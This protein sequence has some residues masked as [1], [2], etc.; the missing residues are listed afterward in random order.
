[1]AAPNFIAAA[2]STIVNET[3]I[4][5]I[6]PD[7]GAGVAAGQRALL[8]LILSP[9]TPSAVPAGWTP[10]ADTELTPFGT[11]GRSYVWETVISSTADVDPGDTVTVNLTGSSRAAL[12]IVVYEAATVEAHSG[13]I[14]GGGSADP[15][16]I[17]PTTTVA[18]EARIVHLYP[19]RRNGVSVTWTPDAATTE[20][21][22]VCSLAGSGANGTILVADEVQAAPGITTGRTGIPT[23][24]VTWSSIAIALSVPVVRPVANAGPNQTVTAGALVALDGS[25]TDGGGPGAPYTWAWSQTGGTAVVLN[26]ATAEDPTFTAPVESDVLT[27]ELVATDSGAVESLPDP[28]TITVLGPEDT[29]VPNGDVDVAGWTPVGQPTVWEALSDG[30][31]TTYVESPDN[32]VDEDF[33]VNLS[34]LTDAAPEDTVVLAVR[35]Q[36]VSA[37]TAEVSVQL[38]EG[39]STVRATLAATPITNDLWNQFEVTFTP[40]E[41][42]GVTDWADVDAVATVSAA[43]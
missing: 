28:V 6:I 18:D 31:D 16:I 13:F 26:D 33:R 42:T 36:R 27:F 40:A 25:A 43:T 34:T 14:S 2:S 32:P 1:M 35:V 19:C 8:T 5:V 37:S 17:T 4:A 29:A 15:A 12:A 10:L 21:V 24:D 20:R 9:S 7:A 41:I 23:G 3:S 11:S 38:I 30:S 39:V 22:D